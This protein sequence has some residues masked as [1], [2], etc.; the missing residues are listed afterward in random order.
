MTAVVDFERDELDEYL[1]EQLRDPAFRVAYEAARARTA[2]LNEAWARMR[3]LRQ[4][5]RR[6]CKAR[7]R[8]RRS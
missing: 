3:V 1:E 8:R 4:E 5:Y 2:A 6:R 7:R